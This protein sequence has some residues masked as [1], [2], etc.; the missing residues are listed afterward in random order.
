MQKMR[1]FGAE[2]AILRVFQ[3]FLRKHITRNSYRR[4]EF[5]RFLDTFFKASIFP[6]NWSFSDLTK[7][8]LSYE[9]LL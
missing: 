9:D 6:K 2:M 7:G 4:K 5:R 8:F 3:T 1:I